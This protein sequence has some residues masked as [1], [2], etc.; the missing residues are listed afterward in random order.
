MEI[1]LRF[2]RD[3]LGLQVVVDEELSGE[4]LERVVGLAGAALRVVELQ[5]EDAFLELIEY[6]AP[7]A[8]GVAAPQ[9]NEV[10]AH[11]IA[12][13]VDDIHDAYTRLGRAGVAFTTE[14]VKITGGALAGSWTTYCLDPDG[15][16]VEL[17]QHPRA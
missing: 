9:P 5:L 7:V 3:L 6:H 2:Y 1:A 16:A 12:L 8:A 17:W 13:V 14:P 4:Q 11:H 15:L 10:G